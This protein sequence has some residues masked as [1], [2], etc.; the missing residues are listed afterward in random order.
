MTTAA[1]PGNV[2]YCIDQTEVIN[3]AY[4]AFVNTPNLPPQEPACSWNTTYVPNGGFQGSGFDAYPVTNVDWCD[5]YAYCRVQGK[6]LCG[7]LGSATVPF[8]A[9]ADASASIWFNACSGQGASVYPYGAQFDPL[10][11]VDEN[12]PGAGPVWDLIQNKPLMTQC[13]G[14]FP[15]LFHMSG[16]VA[17]WEDSCNAQAGASD[18]CRLRG[19]SYLS[20][21]AQVT[22]A[23]DDSITRSTTAP[24]IGF[25]CCQ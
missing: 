12:A 4:V 17:E 22:C 1:A 7:G 15:Q 8:N 19:G 13:A 25:R 3:K 2:T 20:T 21:N 23:A 18:L 14:N 9:F 6:H 16:N 5:A 11:C 24:N 10:L